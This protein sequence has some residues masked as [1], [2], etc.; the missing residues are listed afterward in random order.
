MR[1]IFLITFILAS[2]F[3]EA[4][5]FKIGAFGSFSRD[6]VGYARQGNPKANN[7][8]NIVY[9]YKAGIKGSYSPWYKIS[10][11]PG[12]FISTAEFQDDVKVSKKQVT[13]R[14]K[15]NIDNNEILALESH[16]MT[17]VGPSIGFLFKTNR[18]KGCVTFIT[19][20]YSRSYTVQESEKFVNYQIGEVVTTNTS[21]NYSNSQSKFEFNGSELNFSFGA[22]WHIDS[23]DGEIRLEPKFNI[24]RT[25]VHNEI[26]SIPEITLIN[27]YTRGYAGMGFEVSVNKNLRKRKE[28][29]SNRNQLW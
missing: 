10:L 6:I 19:L 24:F 8:E 23:F 29:G 2:H 14:Y 11:E 1:I 18:H 15:Y 16:K 13:A 7:G 4:Q 17:S 5:T 26:N 3:G 21:H 20:N 28:I 9:R 22:Y 12:L 27:D 25:F